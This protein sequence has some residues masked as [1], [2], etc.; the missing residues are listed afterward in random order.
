MCPESILNGLLP[1]G[2]PLLLYLSSITRAITGSPSC[3]PDFEF[4]VLDPARRIYLCRHRDSGCRLVC[5]FFGGRPDVPPDECRSLLRYEYDCLRSLRPLGLDQPPFQ[6]V[7]PWGKAESLGCLLTEEFVPGHTLDHYIAKACYEDQSLRLQRKLDLL[8]GLLAHLHRSTWMDAGRSFSGQAEHLRSVGRQL[9]AAGIVDST[10]LPM[11]GR[12]SCRWE[13]NRRMWVPMS[14]RVHGDATP[15]NFIMDDDQVTAIDLERMQLADP[16]YDVG[17]FMAELKH[18]FAL[19]VL[20]AERSEPF[21]G[22]FLRSYVS[23]LGETPEFLEELSFRCRFFM[24]LGELR[25]ARN[26][27]L[28]AGHRLWLMEEA[29]RCLE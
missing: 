24:A 3:S 7:R 2:S 9:T 17:I 20:N 5:K 11:L 22:H 21:I 18:H 4:Q 6:V 15:T 8:G 19:W 28:P 23:A 12:H 16:A 14:C 10:W 25:I 26:G 27:W 1:E 13:A 29:M